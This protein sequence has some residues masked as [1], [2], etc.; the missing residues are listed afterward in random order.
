MSFVVGVTGGIGSGKSTVA[1]LLQAQGAAMVDTD[2]IAHTLTAP[3]GEAIELIR[4]EFGDDY[5]NPQGAMDRVQMRQRVFSDDSAKARLE[6]ILHPLI[7][8]TVGLQLQQAQG[9]Y[10]LLVVPLLIETGA[11]RELIDRTL[12]VDIPESMQLQRTMAR[13]GLGENEVR[14]I[15]ARQASRSDRLAV[16]DDVILNDTDL[17]SLQRQVL[18]LHRRYL[19]LAKVTKNSNQAV[20]HL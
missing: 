10:T 20:D 18:S 2:A 12:V 15:M 6:K 14:A 11:Y 7:R 4:A 5:I 1:E 8:Q 3:G 17:E 19:E 16:A 13:S 9:A